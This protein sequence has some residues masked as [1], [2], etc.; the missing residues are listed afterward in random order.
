LILVS[1]DGLS[2]V[3]IKYIT[4]DVVD[5]SY[6]YNAIFRRGLLNTF[7]AALHSLY[8]CLKVPATLGVIS[9]HSS[10]KD[11]R[12]IEHGF[13]LGHRNINCLQDKKADNCSTTAKSESKGS[14]ASKPI[15]PKCECKRVALDPRVLDKTV[16]ISQDITST[17]DTELLSYL[18]KNKDVF[19]WQTS[20]LTG[21]SRDILE[22]KLL[23]VTPSF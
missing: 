1:F 7:E 19:A 11:A 16:M 18:D 8:L 20:D 12:N 17:E 5:M 13:A 23:V 10:Q 2:N 14:P 4:F 3:R 22:H 21:V 15:K 6:P 9:I